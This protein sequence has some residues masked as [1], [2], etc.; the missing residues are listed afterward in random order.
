[1]ALSRDFF[2]TK[3][4]AYATDLIIISNN[5]QKI[6]HVPNQLE[7]QYPV[8]INMYALRREGVN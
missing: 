8:I 5:H 7:Y 3:S 1:M 4:V 2:L 6:K